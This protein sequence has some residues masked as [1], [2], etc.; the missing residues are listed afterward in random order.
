[1]NIFSAT[2]MPA[3]FFYEKR[4][5]GIYS[6]AGTT[7]IAKQKFTQLIITHTLYRHHSDITQKSIA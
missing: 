2:R 5:K 6:F 3:N 7:K 1:M 4:A